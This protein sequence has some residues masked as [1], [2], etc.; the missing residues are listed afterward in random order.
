M[1]CRRFEVT[2]GHLPTSRLCQAQQ[3]PAV[4]VCMLL[5]GY[6]TA[7][8]PAEGRTRL[9]L[10]TGFPSLLCGKH[11]TVTPLP[12]SPCYAMFA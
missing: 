12:R 6:V 11:F 7:A 2:R 3:Q 1:L 4:R 8:P 10:Q 5:D 9:P